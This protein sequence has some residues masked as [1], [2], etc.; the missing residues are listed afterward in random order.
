MTYTKPEV[1]TLGD[2]TH[3]IEQ[4]QTKVH[5]TIVEAPRAPKLNPAYDLDE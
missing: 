2:A 4:T 5:G 3:A 1:A